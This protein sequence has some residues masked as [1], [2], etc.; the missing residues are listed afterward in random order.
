[1][2]LLLRLIT[3]VEGMENKQNI[4]TVILKRFDAMYLLRA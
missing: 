2:D 3:C 4:L 1:M